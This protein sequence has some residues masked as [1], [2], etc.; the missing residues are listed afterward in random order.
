LVQ[1]STPEKRTYPRATALVGGL[2]AG[3]VAGLIAYLF[4]GLS[5]FII[6]FI[7][8]TITGSRATL[9]VNRSREQPS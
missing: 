8:G 4:A 5:G 7:I 3:I 2:I 9:L 1:A 6:A